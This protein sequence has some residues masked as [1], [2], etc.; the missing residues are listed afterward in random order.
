MVKEKK[1]TVKKPKVKVRKKLK[2][3]AMQ[4]SIA[5][6]KKKEHGCDHDKK[7]HGSK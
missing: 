4:E 7:Y 6:E 1:E 3:T 2:R 5:E